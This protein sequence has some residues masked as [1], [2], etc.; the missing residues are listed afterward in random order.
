MNYIF[1]I[2]ILSRLQWVN[3]TK[4]MGPFGPSYIV[5]MF[6]FS[7]FCVI[8]SSWL[9]W[10]LFQCSGVLTPGPLQISNDLKML[11][12]TGKANLFW[13]HEISMDL[14]R[15]KPKYTQY[16]LFTSV[17]FQ[18]LLTDQIDFDLLYDALLWRTMSFSDIAHI[19][20]LSTLIYCT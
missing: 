14:Y 1:Q 15:N 11:S 12:L 16:Y 9:P 13:P 19:L 5:S 10:C 8:H 2:N 6:I 18:I 3:I 4:D 20:V 17:L 7:G